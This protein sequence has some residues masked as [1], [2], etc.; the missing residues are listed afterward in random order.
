MK[1]GFRWISN[2]YSIK[3]FDIIYLI[4]RLNGLENKISNMIQIIKPVKYVDLFMI[5][6]Y[7][8]QTWICLR[9]VKHGLGWQV[10]LYFASFSR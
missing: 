2:K 7:L 8:D 5:R 4:N 10:G 6:I 9:W 1:V 3:I